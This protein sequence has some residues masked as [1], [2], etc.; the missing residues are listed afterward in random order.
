MGL[1]LTLCQSVLL[2]NVTKCH[3]P[4]L[5]AP[6]TRKGVAKF[7]QNTVIITTV[8]GKFARELRLI[9][10]ERDTRFLPSLHLS[11]HL[12]NSLCSLLNSP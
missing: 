6:T 12:V 11:L 1:L 4:Y 9:Q 7:I 2:C 8:P 5:R 3:F 10:R